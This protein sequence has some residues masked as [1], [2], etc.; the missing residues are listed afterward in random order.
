MIP[1]CCVLG[2]PPLSRP[3][4]GVILKGY[5]DAQRLRLALA[6]ARLGDWSWDAASD[7]VTFSGPSGE[8]L[9][10]PSTLPTDMD[11]DARASASRQIASG[12]VR[13]WKR[14]SQPAPT[15]TLNTRLING[16]AERWVSASGLGAYDE[17]GHVVSRSGSVRETSPSRRT[18]VGG[19]R[20]QA[21]RVL[22]EKRRAL[23]RA[24]VQNSSRASGASSSTRRWTTS[25]PVHV[26]VDA[27]YSN[28]RL[29]ECNLMM[30]RMCGWRRPTN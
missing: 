5:S 2:S 9:P 18:R 25:L 10:D 16:P 3:C 8:D 28:G 12:P 13:R 4:P 1:A 27:A 11:G 21:R 20:E 19:A 26:Q 15:T 30:A 24:S 17:A 14:R 22:R 7:V 6:A 23:P 29:A